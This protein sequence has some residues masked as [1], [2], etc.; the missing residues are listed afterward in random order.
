MEV[1]NKGTEA[2][3][4]G[5][6][7]V[8]VDDKLPQPNGATIGPQLFRQRCFARIHVAKIEEVLGREL[9]WCA[10]LLHS[11]LV[12]FGDDAVRREIET[13]KEQKDP[14][15]PGSSGVPFLMVSRSPRCPVYEIDMGWG[16][17]VAVY[18]WTADKFDG[19]VFA[20]QGERAG[21]IDLE[22]CLA[23]ETMARLESD[24]ELMQYIAGVST[25][26]HKPENI[27]CAMCPGYTF[28]TPN[29][30]PNTP[31]NT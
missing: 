1:G 29:P 20:F 3:P 2:K 8:A 10:Q 23:P 30:P 14:S 22:V 12:A 5:G 16:R 7:I 26:K 17:P 13:W 31:T 19:V 27:I 4:W 24:E 25:K 28:L 15:T 18:S 6:D 11:N 21:G 9:S